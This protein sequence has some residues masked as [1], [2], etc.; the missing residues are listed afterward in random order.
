M[1]ENEVK[2]KGLELSGV[3][4]GYRL[5]KEIL[6][7]YEQLSFFEREHMIKWI[8]KNFNQ[9]PMPVRFKK[10]ALEELLSGDYEEA[11]TLLLIK[12]AFEGLPSN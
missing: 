11:N 2:E 5:N 3:V 8:K 4:T 9:I 10:A 6:R 12:Y 1:N 7:Q